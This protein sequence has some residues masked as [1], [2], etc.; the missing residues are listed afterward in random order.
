LQGERNLASP[1]AA[2]SRNQAK[3][4][5]ETIL[6]NVP[7]SVI[8]TAFA[9]MAEAGIFVLDDDEVI[10][11]WSRYM[12]SE[13]EVP[14]RKVLGKKLTDA[15][16]VVRTEPIYPLIRDAFERGRKARLSSTTHQTL[17]RG[18]RLQNFSVRPLRDG[19]SRVVGVVVAVTDVTR[20]VNL[21]E[22]VRHS[23]KLATAGQLA[24]G[25]AHEIGT[26][27][28]IISGTAEYRMREL[29]EGA[30]MR[31]DLEV[32]FSEARRIRGLINQLLDYARVQ[33]IAAEPVSIFA[34]LDRVVGLLRAEMER[35]RIELE[36]VDDPSLPSVRADRDRLQQILINILINGIQAQPEGGKLRIA[37]HHLAKARDFGPRGAVEI[38]ICDW[39]P[40]ISD[41]DARRAFDPFFTTKAPG[42]GTGMG[43]AVAKRLVE[44]HDGTITIGPAADRGTQVTVR[45]PVEH[46]EAR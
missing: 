10:V 46:K 31:E 43:L 40:G 44:E 6:A 8:F 35:G 33:K 1:L 12:E 21:E 27:L 28:G 18:R 45:I 34:V 38:V 11:Y 32:I 15:F 13:Y 30:P 29:P 42:Q 25:I 7:D 9:E 36:R 24:S 22:E 4:M 14:A 2:R 26:P 39:G 20:T 19:K 37:A 3:R 16:P 5:P 23:D 17:N 41:E